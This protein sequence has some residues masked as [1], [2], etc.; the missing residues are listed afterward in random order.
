V[1]CWVRAYRSQYDDDDNDVREIFYDAHIAHLYS[2]SKQ[3]KKTT[4]AFTLS[5]HTCMMQ[6]VILSRDMNGNLFQSAIHI[7]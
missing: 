4:Q 1:R 3:A 6:I 7:G 2:M 5:A